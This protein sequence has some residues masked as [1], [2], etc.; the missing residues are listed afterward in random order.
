MIIVKQNMEKDI[1]IVGGGISGLLA[2]LRISQT[3]PSRQIL[4]LE[5]SNRIGGRLLFNDFHGVN[6]P[7][8]GS[9]IRHTDQ[10]VLQ[11]CR[12]LGL[13][14]KG[15]TSDLKSKHYLWINQFIERL[16]RKISEVTVSEDETVYTYLTRNFTPD[17]VDWFIN[18][19][20]YR[21]YVDGNM[22]QFIK[23]YPLDD[24]VQPEGNG[25]EMYYIEGGYGKLVQAVVKRLRETSSVN[26][27]LETEV[28]SLV[29]TGQDVQVGTSRGEFYGKYI[30]WATGH[31]S[32]QNLPPS[33]QRK[34][35]HVIG[36]PFIRVYGYSETPIP[37]FPELVTSGV[38]GKVFPKSDNVY[39]VAY[40]EGDWA[41]RLAAMLTMEGSPEKRV[42][43]M[44]QLL[45][46]S[47]GREIPLTDIVYQYWSSGIHQYIS[48]KDGVVEDG[49]VVVIGE[50]VSTNQGWVEGCVETV[51]FI[52][53]NYERYFTRSSVPEQFV[54]TPNIM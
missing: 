31:Q 49:L 19:G 50:A 6:V 17:E 22:K 35:D 36:I 47:L 10:R 25:L 16:K 23:N 3:N 53:S 46:Q 8:G 27:Q 43:L 11:L 7:L 26:I 38:I 28:Q 20:V 48:N 9:I 44:S 5:S 29:H 32:Y 14:I 41:V 15:F 24:L 18:N 45:F 30:V 40:V 1:I 34:L 37:D 39:Q 21:D 4:I 12:E 42:K 13:E 2:G 52:M 33:L 51:D 54:A